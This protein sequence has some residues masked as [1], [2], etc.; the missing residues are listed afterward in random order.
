MSAL[1]VEIALMELRIRQTSGLNNYLA[2]FHLIVG[3]VQVLISFYE[4]WAD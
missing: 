3:V 2:V 4:L 1:Y